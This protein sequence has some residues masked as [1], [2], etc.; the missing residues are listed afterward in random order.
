MQL[1][2]EN[3]T[4]AGELE[5]VFNQL[6]TMMKNATEKQANEISAGAFLEG[7]FKNFVMTGGL[8]ADIKKIFLSDEAGRRFVIAIF[9]FITRQA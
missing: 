8:D 9:D 4:K 5:E 6:V 1:S 2:E 7:Y 3:Q